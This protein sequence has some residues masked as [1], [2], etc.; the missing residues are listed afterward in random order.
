MCGG[1]AGASALELSDQRVIHNLLDLP[2]WLMG[3]RGGLG[4][5]G[6]QTAEA[7]V[8]AEGS[9]QGRCVHTH[10]AQ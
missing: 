5:R 2:R 1:D 4:D 7:Q 6:G 8:A 3:S 9:L 10:L